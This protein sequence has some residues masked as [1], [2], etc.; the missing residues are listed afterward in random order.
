MLVAIIIISVSILALGIFGIISFVNFLINFKGDKEKRNKNIIRFVFSTALVLFLGGLNV[1]FIIKYIYDNRDE[2][3][4]AADELITTAIDKS[5]EYTVRGA[6]GTVSTFSRSYN[7]SVIKQFE[8]L[9]ID[10]SSSRFEIEEDQKIYEI[11]VILDNR[12]R[13]NEDIYFGSIVQNNYLI[14][15]DSDDF[16]YRIIPED[17]DSGFIKDRALISLVE[18]FVGREYTKYGKI[19]PGKS[20]HKILVVVPEEVEIS[21]LKYFEKRIEIND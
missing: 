17:A 14:A 1:F 3:A 8:N 18:Y 15:C 7:A 21:Y 16:V 11:E 12:I 6:I 2:I 19:V 4:H 5:V 13:R 10:F 20:L 9:D